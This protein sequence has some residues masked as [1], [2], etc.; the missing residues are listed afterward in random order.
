MQV[1][2]YR[3]LQSDG[4]TQPRGMTDD[5]LPVCSLWRGEETRKGEK[6]RR[7]KCHVF[8]M[9]HYVIMVNILSEQTKPPK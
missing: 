7:G 9:L 1:T 5:V 8:F 3:V 6:E 4:K 2:V